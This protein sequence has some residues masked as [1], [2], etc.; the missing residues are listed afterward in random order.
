[1]CQML[2]CLA[3]GLI[4]RILP[5]HDASACFVCSACFLEVDAFREVHKHTFSKPPGHKASYVPSILSRTFQLGG[6]GIDCHDNTVMKPVPQ[7]V[8]VIAASYLVIPL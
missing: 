6:I 3:F 7:H 2:C 5:F 1:M 4:G 8:H